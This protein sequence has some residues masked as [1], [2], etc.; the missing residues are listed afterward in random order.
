MCLIGNELY[1]DKK[2]AE[3]DD[4]VKNM[5][6]LKHLPTLQKVRDKN[7]KRLVKYRRPS[8]SN[9]T[10]SDSKLCSL[11]KNECDSDVSL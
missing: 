7:K 5:K 3:N 9:F 1:G 4:T 2:D 8:H 6:S 10:F 11:I